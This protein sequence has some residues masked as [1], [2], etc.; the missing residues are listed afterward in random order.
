MQS[1]DSPE[2]SPIQKKAIRHYNYQTFRA[3]AV[4]AY[5]T[6]QA[7]EPWNAKHHFE[8]WIIGGLTVVAAA[9]ITLILLG[10]H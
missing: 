9:G 2:Q 3:E 6:R 7:G 4:E 8:G 10:G 5:T 1:V